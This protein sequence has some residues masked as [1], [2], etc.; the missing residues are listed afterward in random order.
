MIDDTSLK[1]QMSCWLGLIDFEFKKQSEKGCKLDI[2]TETLAIEITWML[3]NIFCLPTPT[4]N[5][6]IFVS[7]DFTQTSQLFYLL[8]QFL[9]SENTQLK[10]M[11]LEAVANAVTN[12]PQVLVAFINEEVLLNTIYS[13]CGESKV[14][15]LVLMAVA[16]I[17]INI[18][19]MK[20]ISRLKSGLDTAYF[21]S[22]LQ[23]LIYSDNSDIIIK[24]IS[25]INCLHNDPDSC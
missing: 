10:V 7:K 16:D 3:T 9:Q 6:I 13:L 23:R 12:N 2:L 17:L 19:S 25:T 21:V 24:G 5:E 11:A 4:V 22:C 1:K 20:L 15:K 18:A 8:N 14:S